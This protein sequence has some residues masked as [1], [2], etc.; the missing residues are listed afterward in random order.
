MT[1]PTSDETTDPRQMATVV[2]MRPDAERLLALTGFLD[3][4]E[5]ALP[6]SFWRRKDGSLGRM[7]TVGTALRSFRSGRWPVT[8]DDVKN[9]RTI[10]SLDR[11][12]DEPDGAS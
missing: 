4:V 10:R 3:R 12:L 11:L 6:Y 1:T 7:T 2:R 8:D 9:A 5:P